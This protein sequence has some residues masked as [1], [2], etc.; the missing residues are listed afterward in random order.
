MDD[1]TFSVRLGGPNR[2]IQALTGLAQLAEEIGFDQAWVGNDFLGHPGIA[3]LASMLIGTNRIQ[4]GSGVLDPV[5]IHPG[6]IAQLACGFQELSGG[7]FILGLGAGS[8]IFFARAGIVPARPVRRTREA[9]VAIRALSEGRSPADE[10]GAAEGWDPTVRLHD[11]HAVKIYLGAMGPKLLELSGRLADGALPLCLPPTHVWNVVRHV[12]KGA[13]AS[14]RSIADLDVAACIWCSIDNDG[15][16]AR[17]LL[18]Q[19]IALYSGSLSPDALTENR[20]DPEEFQHVQSIIDDG[21]PDDAIN[22][23]LASN[24]MM[25]LG[26]AG[27]PH[28]VAEQCTNLLAAGL[29]HISFGP[30]L[31][32]NP[33][34]AIRALGHV[35]PTLRN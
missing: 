15:D 9:I 19:Q 29:R 1:L 18:A 3:A 13:A 24:A 30:P 11:P 34:A 14:G 28:D 20:L 22:A 5:T 26:V 27:S 2:D 8:D 23:T 35:L 7:R 17:R 16:L 31:G 12:E 25:S 32:A 10:P 33:A 4:I 6:Q 21:R